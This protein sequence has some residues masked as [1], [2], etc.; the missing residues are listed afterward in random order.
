MKAVHVLFFLVLCALSFQFTAA[1]SIGQPPKR[2]LRKKYAMV[3]GRRMAYVE[4][5]KGDP[6]V[7]FHGNPTSSY[8]WRNVMP[9]IER[10]GRLIAPDMIGMGDSE[11]LSMTDPS[12]YSLLQRMNYLYTLLERIGVK[13]RVT[14]VMHDWGAMF[15]TYWAYLNRRNPDAIKA[16]VLT[17]PLLTQYNSTVSPLLAGY[18]K[19]YK[20]N[21]GQRELIENNN[22]IEVFIPGQVMRNLT[23]KE[24]DEYRRPYKMPGAARWPVS[25]FPKSLPLDGFP[26]ASVKFFERSAR[27]LA[28]TKVKK[29]FF[30]GI[31]GGQALLIKPQMRTWPNLETINV[32]GLHYV[33]EDSPHVIGKSIS[34]WLKKNFNA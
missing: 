20:S 10:Q 15:G 21:E 18:L 33:Q 4:V 16:I 22:M 17:D 2:F 5:G 3:L 23:E 14:L 30:N 27:W 28:T 29:L 26:R 6:I 12:R 9:H 32:K 19:F 34:K 7:F 25:E 8:L 24:M 13:Q 31:P 11:K 1:Q